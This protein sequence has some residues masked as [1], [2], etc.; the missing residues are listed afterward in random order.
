MIAL[1][2]LG[3]VGVALL[4]NEEKRPAQPFKRPVI[5]GLRSV[6]VA[7]PTEQQRRRAQLIREAQCR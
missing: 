3:A 4:T 1:A 7:W 5:G 6:R 2:V